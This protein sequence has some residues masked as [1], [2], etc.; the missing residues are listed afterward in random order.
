MDT[1][2]TEI[3]DDKKRKQKTSKMKTSFYCH[4]L[5]KG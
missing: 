1:G 5:C 2:L 4:T 3:K